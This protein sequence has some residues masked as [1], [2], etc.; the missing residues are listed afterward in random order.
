MS[1]ALRNFFMGV[2]LV[3]LLAPLVVVAGVSVN[4]K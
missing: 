3:V 2:V 1:N 4:E